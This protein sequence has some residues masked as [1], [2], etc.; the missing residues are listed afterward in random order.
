MQLFKKSIFIIALL[1]IVST[2]F[3]QGCESVND[4]PSSGSIV[5]KI[6]D[7]PF[8][9]DFVQSTVVIID[10]IQ[11]RQVSGDTSKFITIINTPQEFNLLEL[12]N[13]ITSDLPAVDIPIGSYDLARLFVGGARITLNNGMGEFNL[14]VPSGSHTGIKIFIKPEIQIAG[15]LTAEL[16]LDFDLTRSFVALGGMNNIKGFNFKPVIRCVNN[17]L[18]GGLYGIVSDENGSLNGALITITSEDSESITALSNNNGYYEVLGLKAGNYSV[19]VSLD[20]YSDGEASTVEIVA[21]EKT[22]QNFT[23]IQ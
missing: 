7:S 19:S 10:S 15:G 13:G 20:G 22:E 17:S 16:L 12:R 2:F 1:F 18:A 6:T 21:K 11:I 14:N 5:V 9:I 8:P 4:S 23:L 3:I